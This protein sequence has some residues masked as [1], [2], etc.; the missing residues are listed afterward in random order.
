MRLIDYIA[1]FSAAVAAGAA[2]TA[3]ARAVGRR[4]DIL[5]RPD[6]LR[7]RQ[8]RPIPRTGGPAVYLAIVVCVGLAWLWG[9]RTA[10]SLPLLLGAGAVLLVGLWDDVAG[11][12]PGWR[13]VLV[14]LVAAAMCATD[15]RVSAV[16]CPFGGRITFGW[17]AWPVT[18]LWFVGCMT[19]MNFIDGLDGLAGG[20]AVIAAAALF[21]ISLMLGN[22]S[23]ALPLLI[24]AGATLGFLFLN[25]QPASIYL[26]DSGSYALGFL[27]GGIA[28]RAC[29]RAGGGV[30]L[31]IP[32]VTLALP[33]L[34]TAL[35]LLRRWARRRSLLAGSDRRHIHH[36]LL[37]A[38]CSERR[39][40]MLLHGVC[41][42]L[43][44]GAV[45]MAASGRAERWILVAVVVAGVG[46][47]WAVGREDLK[48]AGRRVLG[49]GTS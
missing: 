41:L 31:A 39:A 24:L 12:K 25:V 43:A 34:D 44:L 23:T 33:G 8:S 48:A 38:G 36:R 18:T 11:L 21:V 6:G 2:L 27:V 17:G 13:L 22:R 15:Y 28:L 35:A 4:L 3:L 32:V 16:A 37:D 46:A 10:G 40:A 49:R 1:V 29:E 9:F 26:G 14:A 45:L 5:D 42:L 30:A 47:A 20:T 7:K 19:A